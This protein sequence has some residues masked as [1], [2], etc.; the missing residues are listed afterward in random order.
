MYY[1]TCD[2]LKEGPSI[3]SSQVWWYTAEH[4]KKKFLQ[5]KGRNFSI[6]CAVINLCSIPVLNNV[7]LGSR[8]WILIKKANNNRQWNEKVFSP[9]SAWKQVKCISSEGTSIYNPLPS[10]TTYGRRKEKERENVILNIAT[11]SF[12]KCDLCLQPYSVVLIALCL[13]IL[14]LFICRQADSTFSEV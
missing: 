13:V 9:P 8:Y 6:K 12:L 14:G 1:Y 10:E 7:I 2:N 5:Q 3:G 11:S 4:E